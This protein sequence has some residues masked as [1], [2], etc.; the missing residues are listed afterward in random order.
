MYHKLCILLSRNVSEY[1]GKIPNTAAKTTKQFIYCTVTAARC[2]PIVYGVSLVA[3][4]FWFCFQLLL[5]HCCD[6]D[7]QANEFPTSSSI[8][9]LSTG[10]RSRH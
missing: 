7:H 4:R 9:K 3:L 8:Y 1:V 5:I 10:Y 6:G 2:V